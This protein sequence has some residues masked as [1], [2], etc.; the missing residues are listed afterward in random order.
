MGPFWKRLDHFF[1]ALMAVIGLAGLSY[2][3]F[4]TPAWHPDK[5]AG[6]ALVFLWALHLL[7]KRYQSSG[8][9]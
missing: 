9:D 3:L 2:F 1:D 5:I 7:W 6:V 4:F 8:A